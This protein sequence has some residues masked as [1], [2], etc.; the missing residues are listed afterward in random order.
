[1][2]NRIPPLNI[3]QRYDQF[4]ASVT[5]LDCGRLCSPHNPNG[6]PFCCDIC[7][8]VPAAYR[9]EWDYLRQAT[10]LWHVWR[11]DECAGEPQDP[12][13]LLSDTPEHMLLLACLG[14]AN[15]QREFRAVSCRQ[16]PFFPYLTADWRFIGLAYEYEFEDSCWVISNLGQVSGAY[17]QEFIHFYER[18]FELW[19]EEFN[20]YLAR[21]EE[22]RQHFRAVRRRIPLLHRNGGYYLISPAKERMRRVSPERLPRFGPYRR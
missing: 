20:S 6:K 18:L 1:M 7:Q 16:F 5:S 8:A 12:A 9:L 4:D 19:P 13:Q 2:E 17:R 10:D 21:S 3:R 15:C 11:G 22:L 14:P